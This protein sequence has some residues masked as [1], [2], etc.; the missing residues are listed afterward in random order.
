MRRWN[1]DEETFVGSGGAGGELVD[2][3]WRRHRREFD[4]FVDTPIP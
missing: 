1:F 2:A 4:E 3:C